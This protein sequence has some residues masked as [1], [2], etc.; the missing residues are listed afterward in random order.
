MLKSNWPHQPLII[1]PVL[2]LIWTSGWLAISQVLTLVGKQVGQI[3][4]DVVESVLM[5]SAVVLVGNVYNLILI[6]QQ[7]QLLKENYL[8]Q[9]LTI[10]WALV[11]IVTTVL[12]WGKPSLIL[13]PTELSLGPISFLILN[14]CQALLGTYFVLV[15]RL[16]TR[17]PKLSLFLG[18]WTLAIAGVGLPV[19]LNWPNKFSAIVGGGLILI[20]ILWHGYQVPR[21]LAYEPASRSG[22]YQMVIGWTLVAGLTSLFF[23]CDTVVLSF[24]GSRLDLVS[25]A[26]TL[27]LLTLGIGDEV[28]A[29]MQRYHNDYRYGHADGHERSYLVGGAVIWVVSLL[30]TLWLL[31]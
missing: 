15:T 20:L 7:Q 29:G 16:K 30:T 11:L 26:F 25:V 3:G 12:A 2:P 28:I 13:T 10:L 4:N 18:I 23:G 8:Y 1:T 5:V 9:G 22:I 21:M 27:A 6:C 31:G 17:Q 19:L 14:I 24:L